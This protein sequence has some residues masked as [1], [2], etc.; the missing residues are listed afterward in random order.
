MATESR[1]P[2]TW[3]DTIG[4]R[5]RILYMR[6]LVGGF[7]D[8]PQRLVGFSLGAP[9]LEEEDALKVSIFTFVRGRVVKKMRTV[10]KG[11]IHSY[12]F[13]IGFPP[14]YQWSPLDK[15]ATNKGTLRRDFFVVMPCNTD[16]RY[17][18]FHRYVE[19]VLNEPRQ[20]DAMITTEDDRTSIHRI[21]TL[22]AEEQRLYWAIGTQEQQTLGTPQAIW[23]IAFH[24][25]TCDTTDDFYANGVYVG[26]DADTADDPVA[27]YSTNRFGSGSASTESLATASCYTCCHSDGATIVYGYSDEIVDD[28]GTAV[29][30]GIAY[31]I[32]AG[33]NITA[34]TGVTDPIYCVIQGAGYWWAAGSASIIWRS[35]DGVNW[36]SFTNPLVSATLDYVNMAYDADAG[37]IYLVGSDT[38]NGALHRIDRDDIADLTSDMNAGA[39]LMYDVAVLEK[40]HVIAVGASGTVREQPDTSQTGNWSD[41]SI[42]TTTPDCRFVGGDKARTMIGAGSLPYER[43]AL[44]DWIFKPATIN[45][46]TTISGNIVSGTDGELLEGANYFAMGTDLGEVLL[47]LPHTPDA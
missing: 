37:Y 2:S 8:T 39:N 1:Y 30:G 19:G 47:T 27:E 31:S 3:G 13:E 16:A 20:N 28:A 26:G 44:Q 34:V 12:S 32:D 5:D 35:K 4:S 33:V 23:G 24:V 29:A 36:T 15:V 25:P 18:S 7:Y 42:G 11:E 14:G 17:G 21:S 22:N 38:P 41:V 45:G 6:D 10:A 43:S 40:N 46:G 9:E